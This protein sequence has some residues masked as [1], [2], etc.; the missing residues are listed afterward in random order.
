MSNLNGNNFFTRRGDGYP[1]CKALYTALPVFLF[2]LILSLQKYSF[3]QEAPL[4]QL[5]LRNAI[6][7]ALGVNVNL[8]SAA[9]SK[10]DSEARLKVA[11]FETT[12]A[13]TAN[14]SIDRINKETDGTA[15]IEG[16]LTYSGLPGTTADLSLSPIGVGN[17]RSSL[18]LTVRHPLTR[19]KGM[20]SDKANLV[21]NARSSAFIY[22]N[23]YFLA[24]QN[25]IL[26]VMNAYYN[27]IEARELVKEQENA[28]TYVQQAAIYAR[29]REEAGIGRGIDVSRAEVTVAQT[30]D[31]LNIQRA[32]ARAAMD[33]LMIAIGAGVGKTYELTDPIPEN[34]PPLPPLEEAIQIALKNR[35][36]LSTYDQRIEDQKRA[37][38]VA[39]DKMRNALDA[40][41]SISSTNEDSGLLRG[42]AI[43]EGAMRVGVQLRIP[44]DK[45]SLKEDVNISTRGLDVLQQQK[46]FRIEQIANEVRSAYRL[47]DSANTSL[48]I[49]TQNLSQAQENLRIAERMVEEGEGD[50]RDVLDAQSGLTRV[51]SSIISAKINLY[52]ATM[53]V[54]YAMGE[55][56]SKL[57][58]L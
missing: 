44:L 8:K 30:E 6:D 33:S 41:A 12:Y 25:L 10:M 56:L 49:F 57:G 23:E 24:K 20:L 48:Q 55:D 14:T 21:L 42:S 29:K 9:A 27:A 28:L 43:D 37:V 32:A 31:Q 2:I 4:Q 54:R 11:G 36:E 51:N 3:A 34:I 7:M 26:N 22:G 19:G 46:Q 52:L 39:K 17:D 16:S 53:N 1:F 35:V 50:N 5:S 15:S 38:E 45:R 40:V 13:A 58:Q 18:N 47:F